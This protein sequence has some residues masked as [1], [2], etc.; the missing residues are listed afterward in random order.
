MNPN[1]PILTRIVIRRNQSLSWRELRRFVMAGSIPSLVFVGFA[2]YAGWWPIVG[3]CVGAFVLLVLLLCEVMAGARDR[4][5]VTV[6]ARHIMVEVGR[7]RPQMRVEL[8]RY[9]ARVEQ[10]RGPPPALAVVSRGASVE[11]G[12]ALSEAQR[13]ALA[14]RLGALLGPRADI[15]AVPGGALDNTGKAEADQS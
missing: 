5:V 9:W 10:R 6:T 12:A 14:H 2:I 15:K 7:Y 8:D 11:V 13:K 1:D 4:E 3:F